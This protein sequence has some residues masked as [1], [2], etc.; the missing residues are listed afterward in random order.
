MGILWRSISHSLEY[1]F[2]CVN[3]FNILMNE[4]P[5][6]PRF[7]TNTKWISFKIYPQN[8]LSSCHF[9]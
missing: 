9:R 4:N 2:E 1:Y 8:D 5:N 7:F 6:L 3:N